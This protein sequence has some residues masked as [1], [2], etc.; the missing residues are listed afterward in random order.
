MISDRRQF[1][2]LNDSLK[3]FFHLQL[4]YYRRMDK[5]GLQFAD[6]CFFI[7]MMVM[8]Y[9]ISKVGYTKVGCYRNIGTMPK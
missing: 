8:I 3:T 6:K 9:C 4:P 2:V 5:V 7:M 1:V